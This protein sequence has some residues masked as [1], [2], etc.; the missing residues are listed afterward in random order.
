MTSQNRAGPAVPRRE[1]RL[2]R[3]Q[4]LV[5]KQPYDLNRIGT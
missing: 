5:T 1:L 3:I 4:V 2:Q